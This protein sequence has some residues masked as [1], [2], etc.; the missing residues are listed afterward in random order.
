MGMS[1]TNSSTLKLLYENNMPFWKRKCFILLILISTTFLGLLTFYAV[2]DIFNQGRHLNT[3]NNLNRPLRSPLKIE[4]LVK[5]ESSSTIPY[6]TQPYNNSHFQTDS[7]NVHVQNISVKCEINNRLTN[8][9]YEIKRLNNSLNRL[10]VQFNRDKRG[11]REETTI[12]DCVQMKGKFNEIYEDIHRISESLSTVDDNGICRC[13]CPL[14][15]NTTTGTTTKVSY[16]TKIPF[17]QTTFTP[18]NVNEHAPGT[19]EKTKQSKKIIFSKYTPQSVTNQLNSVSDYE[20]IT[21]T[22]NEETAFTTMLSSTLGGITTQEGTDRTV[23]TK[24]DLSPEMSNAV[25]N[26]V[27][28]ED[29]TKTTVGP[30][31]IY[32]TDI[33]TNDDENTQTHITYDM[34]TSSTD[35]MDP[36]ETIGTTE[37][38]NDRTTTTQ[39]KNYS[40]KDII[41]NSTAENENISES[42]TEIL[43][44]EN[45]HSITYIIKKNSESLYEND[46][47]FKSTTDASTSDNTYDI[48]YITENTWESSSE[49]ENISGS[50]TEISEFDISHNRTHYV[51]EKT[52]QSTSE[53]ENTSELTT[54]ISELDK[55]YSETYVTEKTSESTSKIENITGSI[56]KSS[57]SNDNNNFSNT[58]VTDGTVDSIFENKTETPV[59]NKNTTKAIVSERTSSEDRGEKHYDKPKNGQDTDQST[60][61]IGNTSTENVN[62]LMPNNSRNDDL[63]DKS[64][65]QQPEV[66]QQVQLKP[67]PI[68]FYPAPCSPNIVNYQQIS[69]LQDSSKS[70]IQYTAQSLATYK[71]KPPVATVIQNDY[72]VL[73]ICRTDVICSV[74]DFAG[75]SNRLHC[76]YSVNVNKNSENTSNQ[77]IKK[78]YNSTKNAAAVTSV[79]TAA[80]NNDDILTGNLDCPS[81]TF[82]CVDNSGCVDNENWCDG[83]IHCNDASD[84][85]QCNCKQRIDKDKLCDGYY[86]CPSGED[87]LGCFGC[88]NETFSCG[89]WDIVSQRSSCFERKNRCDYVKN[90]PNGRDEDECTLLSRHLEN[91]NQIFFISYSSGYL[92]HNWKGNWYPMCDNDQ[93]NTWAEK[94]CTVESG[95]ISKP[96]KVQYMNELTTYN[97][98]YI[99]ID[100]NNQIILSNECNHQG[101][102]V[103]CEPEMCGIRSDLKF[104][105]NIDPDRLRRSSPLESSN[106]ITSRFTRSKDARVVGGIASNPG[107]WPWLIALYQDGIFHCGGVILSDQW[108][109]TAAHCVNQYKKHFYEVQAGI[110]RRFSFSPM[111]QSRIVTHA[112]IHTQYSRSTMENDL[113]V[114]RLDR[115]LEFN[116]WIRPVCLPDNKLSWIPFPGTMCTAVGWGATVEHGPD[117]DNMRE[118][119]VPILAECTHKSD[120]EGKEICAGYLN[121]GHDTCQGDSGGPLLCREP[122]NLNKWYVAGIVSHGEGCARP[123]EPGVYTRVALYMDWIFKATENNLPQDSPLQYCPGIRCKTGK[124]CIPTKRQCDKYVDCMNAEDEQNCDYTGSQYQVNLYRSRNTDHSNLKYSKLKSAGQPLRDFNVNFTMSTPKKTTTTVASVRTDITPL[125]KYDNIS[126]NLRDRDVVKNETRM[127]VAVV[128]EKINSNNITRLND[129]VLNALSQLFDNQFSEKTFSCKRITQVVLSNHRCDGTVD[130]EDGTDEEACDC[131]TRLTNMFNS[132]AIC[133]GLVD[134]HNGLDEADCV[135]PKCKTDETA[136]GWPIKCVKKSEWCD[137]HVNCIDGVDEKYCVA[138]TNGTTAVTSD[139]TGRPTLRQSGMV[140]VNRN[141]VW[142]VMCI[143]DDAVVKIAHDT[144]SDLGYSHSE[145]HAKRMSWNSALPL[146]TNRLKITDA[147]EGLF[148]ECSGRKT[149]DEKRYYWHADV[150][151]D[152]TLVQSG[153]LLKDSW[154]LVKRTGLNL[155]KSYVTAVLGGSAYSVIWIKSPYEQ[156]VRVDGIREVPDTDFDLLH[157]AR[158][159]TVSRGVAPLKVLPFQPSPWPNGTCY[160][161]GYT[162]NQHGNKTEV[163]F[164]RPDTG[165]CDDPNEL[166]F[167]VSQTPRSCSNGKN[168]SHVTAVICESNYGLFLAA[169]SIQPDMNLCDRNVRIRLPM[170]ECLMNKIEEITDE[171]M[172]TTPVP[173]CG[174]KRCELG[175]C[176]PWERVCDGIPDCR[177]EQDE[178]IKMCQ[179]RTEKCKTNDTLCI[180]DVGSFRCT[181]GKCVEKTAF[182]DGLNNCG[183][184]TDEP[185]TC[186]KNTCVD[187]LKL[188]A[189]ERLCDGRWD[190]LDKTD[191]EFANCPGYCNR[192]N[193]YHCQSSNKCIS[194]EFV[195]D[196]EEDCPESDD[197]AECIGLIT[198]AGKKNEGILAV[199][200]YGHWH[201][202]CITEDYT[203]IDYHSLCRALG[204]RHAVG[205]KK[206]AGTGVD[207]EN[208]MVVQLNAGTDVTIR[209]ATKDI[210]QRRTNHACTAT[211]VMCS[212]T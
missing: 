163:A 110:L 19:G 14:D 101:I 210:L 37:L 10:D 203:D 116:R 113:A 58:R 73:L 197:E 62:R 206:A 141:G 6:A 125:P 61:V 75:Q 11:L 204:F 74:A 185:K 176:V 40:N 170:A 177:D 143:K 201:E 66:I 45:N 159:A 139:A 95:E 193:V 208:F 21:T 67:Y 151:V 131:K 104:N 98:P 5:S 20:I 30:Q 175:E 2:N 172:K 212:S 130:C 202:Q 178:T 47:I 36:N 85:S 144:C 4:N 44:S 28:R 192:T 53:N 16:L 96:N 87:E 38:N 26:I 183:D 89:D 39:A 194:S 3:G 88:N 78:H 86:D 155:N 13:K 23:D 133:D 103:E 33:I 59:P 190:C 18:I 55:N 65:L 205:I 109:L 126:G 149:V 99:N 1:N 34:S 90:C 29:G 60:T 146:K 199:R 56:T 145:R 198:P 181:N 64:T 93:I 92:H 164:L 121:G 63:D 158:P 136:C 102:F 51:I 97:G 77:A 209:S 123:M 9:M 171:S 117:P 138:I 72:P 43:G 100:G 115:S 169:P 184:G 8:L 196:G 94:A 42:T 200:S 122:N 12:V 48:T 32:L 150:V 112:I 129:T 82:P 182:C 174:G 187:Y 35:I 111:E 15:T 168:M 91:P 106:N 189:P 152:G 24:G 41:L 105:K 49:N 195:C 17:D 7:D 79:K 108:V 137:G 107:A 25:T 124:Q 119:E 188:T 173:F 156:I 57:S 180:C 167:T 160:A 46:N 134:C 69:E 179:Q 135:T 120:I 165:Q 81:N 27:N 84:E 147:C 186:E 52:I 207:F 191:E 114:L 68:C 70:A 50:T 153:V 22:S 71:R 154:V 118:V 31:I 128:N 166:C 76:M 148:V 132:S 157:L 140:A 142:R 162:N 127:T 80:R 83:R 54:E 211:Y 161:I